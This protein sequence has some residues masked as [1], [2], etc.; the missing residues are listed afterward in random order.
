[1]LTQNLHRRPVFKRF[2]DYGISLFGFRRL[3]TVV[4]LFMILCAST[5]FNINN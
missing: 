1:M 5:A 2:A 4:N 3:S